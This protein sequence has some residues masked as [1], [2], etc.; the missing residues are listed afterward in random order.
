LSARV[1]DPKHLEL[2][3]PLPSTTGEWVRI[4]VRDTDAEASDRD[5][6]LAA[7]HDVSEDLLSEEEL[8]YYLELEEL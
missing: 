3:E 1:L 7:V 8:A 6:E 4:V 2:A 5:L